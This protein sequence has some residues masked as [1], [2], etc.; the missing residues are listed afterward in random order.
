MVRT[1]S[2]PERTG[3]TI[4]AKGLMAIDTVH[5]ALCPENFE[6]AYDER[7]FSNLGMIERHEHVLKLYRAV[8]GGKVKYSES[9]SGELNQVPQKKRAREDDN[10]PE[11]PQKKVKQDRNIRKMK[12]PKKFKGLVED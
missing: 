1:F 8:V 12:E 10:G 7:D 6:D 2:S 11:M 3:E 9:D 4:V 5:Q